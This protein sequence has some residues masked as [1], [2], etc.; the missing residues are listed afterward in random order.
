[1]I[2]AGSSICDVQKNLDKFDYAMTNHDLYRSSAKS[3]QREKIGEL[4]LRVRQGIESTLGHLEA[5]EARLR[6][7][8]Q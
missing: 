2:G 8:G 7:D 1:M 3:A 6:L 4:V 5:L